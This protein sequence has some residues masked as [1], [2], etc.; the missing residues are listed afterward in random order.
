MPLTKR[1]ICTWRPQ[2]LHSISQTVAS[3]SR[4]GVV[5]NSGVSH[6][7]LDSGPDAENS[8]V[9]QTEQR[10][11]AT[12]VSLSMVSTATIPAARSMDDAGSGTQ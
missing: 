6:D 9:S 12:S 2:I 4:E 3:T 11:D 1:S 5:G 10:S 7:G 8:G